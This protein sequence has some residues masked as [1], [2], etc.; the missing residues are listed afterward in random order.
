MSQNFIVLAALFGLMYFML[1]RPQKKQMEARKNMMDN[2]S[3]GDVIATIGGI[4]GKVVTIMENAN[5]IEIA[6][7]VNIE[8]LKTAVGQVV[9]DDED[10]DEEDEDEDE[11]ED[12]DT[13]E[14]EED[15]EQEVDERRI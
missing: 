9:T 2:L 8:I 7:S 10:E 15:D 14:L 12:D 11:Y 5:I 3:E 6:E 1:I 4:K 13:E